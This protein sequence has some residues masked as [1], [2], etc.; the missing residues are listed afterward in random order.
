MNLRSRRR[1]T[2]AIAVVCLF[3]F[4]GGGLAA[5][6]TQNDPICP[7]GKPWIKRTSQVFGPTTYVCP[8]GVTVSQ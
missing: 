2:I 1:V 6:L 8:G 7:G 3:V 5:H 4:L